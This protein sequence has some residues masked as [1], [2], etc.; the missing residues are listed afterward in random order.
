M[1]LTNIKKASSLEELIDRCWKKG[2]ILCKNRKVFNFFYKKNNKNY[3]ILTTNINNRLNSFLGF[4]PVSKFDPIENKKKDIC[5]IALW[6]KDK[7]VNTFEILKNF[8]YLINLKKWKAICVIGINN[9]VRK[10]YSHFGFK[11]SILHHFYSNVNKFKKVDK[12]LFLNE[13]IFY[14]KKKI[15]KFKNESYKT[16]NFIKNKYLKNPFYKYLVFSIK[17]DTSRSIFVARI[18]NNKSFG[19]TIFRVIDFSGD[20]NSIILF[21]DKLIK[22]A[23]VYNCNYLDFFIGGDFKLKFFSKMFTKSSTK[24]FLPIYF[25]PLINKF[26]KIN[27]AY[28]KNDVN[29]KLIFFKGDG[30]YDRPNKII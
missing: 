29:M 30:D 14:D 7:N 12:Q 20:E 26:N 5:F 24:K 23:S 6:F 22:L 15:S 11:L 21:K 28:K 13:I 9:K 19:F 4:I 25:E 17:S 3:N 10:L 8:N 1:Q 18:I 2:H 27:I 16:S